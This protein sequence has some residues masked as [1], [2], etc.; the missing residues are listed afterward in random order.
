M[1]VCVDGTVVR[2]CAMVNQAALTGEPL[3]V[4]RTVGDD[5]FAGTAVEDGE[6][7]VRG[8]GRTSGQTKLRSIVN[9][10][11]QSEV[12]Q[13]PHAVAHASALPTASCR[14]TSCLRALWRLPR[15]AW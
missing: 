2:G 13:G 7:I 4:E 9:L 10:V 5:V 6:I 1:P 14:G 11:E 12:L 3:A 15:A 8:E